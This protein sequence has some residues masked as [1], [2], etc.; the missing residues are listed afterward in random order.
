MGSNRN[1][2]EV[3]KRFYFHV[4]KCKKVRSEAH[5]CE[6]NIGYE[7]RRTKKDSRKMMHL[8]ILSFILSNSVVRDC[9]GLNHATFV[10]I[11]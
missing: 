3:H 2:L 7:A 4:V 8:F 10:P 9:A 11:F 6:R 1:S 5:G